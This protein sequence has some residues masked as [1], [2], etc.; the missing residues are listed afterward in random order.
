MIEGRIQT[1][2]N[3]KILG[4]RIRYTVLNTFDLGRS[5]VVEL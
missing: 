3:G 5:H 2:T 4:I 1:S